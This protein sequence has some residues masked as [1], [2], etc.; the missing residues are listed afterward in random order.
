MH[1]CLDK[2][3]VSKFL[4]FK[5]GNKE[6]DPELKHCID[7]CEQWVGEIS[8]INYFFSHFLESTQCTE[9]AKFDFIQGLYSLKSEMFVSI[10]EFDFDFL[11]AILLF[12]VNVKIPFDENLVNFQNRL[13]N[14]DFR[15]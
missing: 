4:H 10:Q 8:I 1:Y 6:L 2:D 7:N 12:E 13:K 11:K 3:E 9:D 15:S 5:Y 14:Y